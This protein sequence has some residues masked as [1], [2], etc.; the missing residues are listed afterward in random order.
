MDEIYD[1][2]VFENEQMSKTTCTNAAKRALRAIEDRIMTSETFEWF[3]EAW[4]DA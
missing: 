2:V 4:K 1:A 3:P